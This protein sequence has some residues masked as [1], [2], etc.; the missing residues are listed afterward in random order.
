MVN[1]CESKFGSNWQELVKLGASPY[2]LD[3]LCDPSGT[4]NVGAK[5]HEYKTY[6][7]TLY[8]CN[9]TP[10]SYCSDFELALIQWQNATVTSSPPE[11][12]VELKPSLSFSAWDKNAEPI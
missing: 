11:M 6:L 2:S 7:D 3:N 1:V 10:N 5:L 4:N 8:G 12:L 9:V